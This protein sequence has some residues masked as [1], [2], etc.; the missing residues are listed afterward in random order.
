MDEL[1]DA[2]MVD[3][4]F[5]VAGDSL[6][7]DHRRLLA[8][9]VEAVLPWLAQTPGAGLHRLNVAAGGGSRALLSPRTR[10]TLRVP[11]E[12]AEAARA[13]EGAELRLD[14]DRLRIGAA[15]ERPLRP[16]GTLYAHLVTLADPA[17]A[18]A[19]PVDPADRAGGSATEAAAADPDELAFLQAAE[20][21]L[22]ALGVHGRA[23][24]G[25]LQAIG[26][27]G[28]HGYSLMLDGLSAADA[29]RLLEAGL[30]LHRRLGCGVFV[31]HKSAAA[32]GAPP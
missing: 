29:L 18:P 7:R 16:W 13:L 12:R 14:D 32:V 20:A 5:A 4:A 24:C 25:R 31:P 6:P 26:A 21:Q 11:C 19:G 8:A 30:G 2:T 9:A 27:E 28:L 3:I 10:L 15:H 17:A 1:P 22:A 23:I